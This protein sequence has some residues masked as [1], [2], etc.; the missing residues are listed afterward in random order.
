MGEYI[1]WKTGEK[2]DIAN[3]KDFQFPPTG[4]KMLLKARPPVAL[5]MKTD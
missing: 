5:D 3:M 2:I 1:S 4:D